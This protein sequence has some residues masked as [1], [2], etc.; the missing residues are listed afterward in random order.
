MRA[1]GIVSHAQRASDAER[2]ARQAERAARAA[3][4][5]AK[6]ITNPDGTPVRLSGRWGDEVRTLVTARNKLVDTINDARQWE[7]MHAAR[8]RV[9][10]DPGSIAQAAAVLAEHRADLEIL[11]AA[12]AYKLDKT[13][14]E[15]LAEAQVKADAKWRRETWRH[16]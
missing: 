5:A 10:I 6:G 4:K 7:A 13:R 9:G 2:S 3:A 16:S 11:L 14:E 1:R 12:I 15:V 8:A